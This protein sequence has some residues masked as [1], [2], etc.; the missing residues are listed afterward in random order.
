[1]KNG[2]M[3]IDKFVNSGAEKD[4]GLSS[5]SVKEIKSQN[6]E[7]LVAFDHL[8]KILTEKINAIVNGES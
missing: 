1:M 3:I 4:L 6:L 7:D 2:E 5:D 8:K